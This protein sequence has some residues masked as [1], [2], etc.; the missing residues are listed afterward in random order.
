V[1]RSTKAFR[2]LVARR[3]SP[4][5]VVAC[6]ALFVALAGTGVAAVVLVP[7]NSVGTVQL[8]NSAVVSHGRRS[9]HTTSRL[10]QT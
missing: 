3:P 1:A 5:L 10:R 8:K 7:K 4:A 9:G 2:A 6:L